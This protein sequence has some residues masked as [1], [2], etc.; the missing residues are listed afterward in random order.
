MPE[1]TLWCTKGVLKYWP[2]IK[3]AARSLVFV[4]CFVNQCTFPHWFRIRCSSRV[5]LFHLCY[6]VT[7]SL[8]MH[9]TCSGVFLPQLPWYCSPLWDFHSLFCILGCRDTTASVGPLRLTR[10]QK[11]AL[12]PGP[13]NAIHS[14]VC[15][16][17]CVYVCVSLGPVFL[18]ATPGWKAVN[19][20]TT[21]KENHSLFPPTSHIN[22]AHLHTEPTL[23]RQQ[24]KP[25]ALRW[26]GW[27]RANHRSINLIS[28]HSPLSALPSTRQLRRRR[29]C[30]LHARCNYSHLCQR[31][32]TYDREELSCDTCDPVTNE[33]AG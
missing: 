22:V 3:H 25:W 18:S 5:Q 32:I 10:P 33:W 16:C 15:V 30:G 14:S 6:K 7:S 4:F 29:L 20:T 1:Q 17:I 21:K 2:N 31:C 12:I 19:T 24:L 13:W 28:I 11:T 9:A 23:V 27:A 26:K 8:L